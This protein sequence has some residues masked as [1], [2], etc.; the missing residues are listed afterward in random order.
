MISLTTPWWLRCTWRSPAPVCPQQVA[1]P[2]AWWHPGLQGTH[3]M[4]WEDTTQR[5]GFPRALFL[6]GFPSCPVFPAEAPRRCHRCKAERGLESR[7]QHSGPCDL[8]VFHACCHQQFSSPTFCHQKLASSVSA[9]FP[10]PLEVPISGCWL[11]REVGGSQQAASFWWL[12]LCE[13][14]SMQREMPLLRAVP[15]KC[16]CWARYRLA[17]PISLLPAMAKYFMPE[18]IYSPGLPPG[19][20]QVLIQGLSETETNYF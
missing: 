2:T 11:Q 14:P 10:W 16:L 6:P 7:L 13:M 19:F 5:A 1:V 3:K 12:Q 15:Q 17:Q 20:P 9:C 8:P 4:L 18:N